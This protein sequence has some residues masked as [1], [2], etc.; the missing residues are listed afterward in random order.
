MQINKRKDNNGRS[1]QEGVRRNENISRWNLKFK[2][3]RIENR[4]EKKTE[5]GWVEGRKESEGETWE[6]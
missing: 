1:R 6:G 4:V 2:I 5:Y 3:K